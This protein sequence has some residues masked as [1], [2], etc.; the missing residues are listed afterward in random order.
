M[1]NVV[2]NPGSGPVAESTEELAA[3]NMKQFVV[4]CN[5]AWLSFTRAA[6]RDYGNG[7]FAFLLTNGVR[8]H[9]IQMPGIPLEKVRFMGEAAQNIWDFPRMYVDGSSWVWRVGILDDPRDWAA[10]EK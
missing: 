6:D 5:S 2:I 1:V 8:T 3:E 9:E 10:S 7:R 4:D